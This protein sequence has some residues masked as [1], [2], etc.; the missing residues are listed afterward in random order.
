MFGLLSADGGTDQAACSS[1]GTQTPFLLEVEY[2]SIKFSVS[3]GTARF[4][5][6]LGRSITSM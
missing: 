4:L 2:F 1:F 3:H 5:G 6:P